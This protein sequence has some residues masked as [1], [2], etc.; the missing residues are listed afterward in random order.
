MMK[1]QQQKSADRLD[2]M[3]AGL[4]LFFS[5]YYIIGINPQIL[6]EVGMP[7]SATLF[8]TFLA[9]HWKFEWSVRDTHGFDDSTRGRN[10]CVLHLICSKLPT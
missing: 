1:I 2:E 8:G 3:Y 6:K 10:K 5:M 9:N 7:I 4:A